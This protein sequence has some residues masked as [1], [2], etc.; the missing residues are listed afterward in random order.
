MHFGSK[1]EKVNKGRTIKENTVNVWM[2]VT[3]FHNITLLTFD[4]NCDKLVSNYFV[5]VLK[6]GLHKR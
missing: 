4:Q 6:Y 3:S 2:N 5:E 1:K